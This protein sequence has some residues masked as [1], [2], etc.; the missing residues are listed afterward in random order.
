MRLNGH[1]NECRLIHHRI[2]YETTHM[3]F[4]MRDHL[5]SISCNHLRGSRQESAKRMGRRF[6]WRQAGKTR[7]R[8]ARLDFPSSF[9]KLPVLILL[10][11][12]LISDNSLGEKPRENFL[13]ICFD[14]TCFALEIADTPE[15]RKQGLMN[16]DSLDSGHGMLFIFEGESRYSI[17]MKNMK[18]SIDILWLDKDLK[19]IHMVENVPPCITSSCESVYPAAPARYVLELPAAT[20]SSQKLKPGMTG[21]FAAL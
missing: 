18:F 19:I 7:K 5:R 20:A 15:S 8:E 12:S 14:Q 2:I 3:C 21:A 9:L 11:L 17:W 4:V 1:R 10:I 13:Q 16:R 6:S